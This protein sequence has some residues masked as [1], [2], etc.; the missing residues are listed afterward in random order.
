MKFD[1]RHSEARD[2]VVLPLTAAQVETR[3]RPV[4]P[5]YRRIFSTLLQ[6]PPQNFAAFSPRRGRH[7]IVTFALQPSFSGVI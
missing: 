5:S 6:L 7:T 1:L 4:F 2:Q 3:R